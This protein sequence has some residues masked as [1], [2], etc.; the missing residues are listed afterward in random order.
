MVIEVADNG[1]GID[2]QDLPR[3][4]DRGYR[5]ALPRQSGMYMDTDHA[6]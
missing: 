4:F 2:P 3:I 5:G 1:P 6:V